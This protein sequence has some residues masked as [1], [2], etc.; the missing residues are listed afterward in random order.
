MVKLMEQYLELLNGTLGLSLLLITLIVIRDFKE[1]FVSKGIKIQLPV[2]FFALGVLVFSIKEL[3]KYGPFNG[4][5]SPVIAE[6][7]ETIHLLLTLA[8]VSLLLRVK[9]TT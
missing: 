7:L 1:K 9:D 3:Y 8:A 4:V 6:L 2:A 5:S